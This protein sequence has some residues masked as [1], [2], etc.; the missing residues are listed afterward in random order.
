MEK[1][2]IVA[3]AGCKEALAERRL[4]R[5][6]GQT[7]DA[8]PRAAKKRRMISARQGDLAPAPAQRVT[9]WR[10]MPNAE[11]VSLALR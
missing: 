7:S 4:E 5:R 9:R 8:P 11:A 2:P 1:L 3:A 10:S 6:R